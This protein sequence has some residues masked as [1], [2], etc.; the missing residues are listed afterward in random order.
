MADF[1]P[2]Q[3]IP[4]SFPLG[5]LD[6]TIVF[7]S[8]II[9]SVIIRTI[10]VSLFVFFILRWMHHKGIGQLSMFE[11]LII[12]GLGSAIGDPMIYT[13]QVS[14]PQAF[15]AITVVIAIFKAIDYLTMKSKRFQRF[16]EEEPTLLV[17]DGQFSEDGLKKARLSKKEYYA[18]M[19]LG[20]IRD[21][22]EIDESYLEM[23]GQISFIRKNSDT[24]KPDLHHTKNTRL[25]AA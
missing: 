22:S 16:A 1:V 8:D 17:K 18:H 10:I 21:I 7:D 11:L 25:S 15:V 20:G 13:K 6:N 4:N 2:N 23:N 12:I 24:N 14:L 19:R 3:M 5:F 9:L